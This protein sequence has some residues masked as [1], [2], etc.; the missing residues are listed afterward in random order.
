MD[1]DSTTFNGPLFETLYVWL[2]RSQRRSQRKLVVVSY[3][4]AEKGEKSGV[5]KRGD[6]ILC[7]DAISVEDFMQPGPRRRKLAEW[8]IPDDKVV[9]GHGRVL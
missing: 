8:G 1:S 3:A 9:V 5:F 6:W 4:N 2:E 7:R